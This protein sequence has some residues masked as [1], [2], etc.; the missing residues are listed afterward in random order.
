MRASWIVPV[1]IMV[2]GASALVVGLHAASTPAPQPGQPQVTLTISL[3][4]SGQYLYSPTSIHFPERTLVQITI[5]NYDTSTHLTLPLYDNVS[6]TVG[7]EVDASGGWVADGVEGSGSIH[8]VAPGYIS[9]TF[10]IIRNAYDVNVPIPAASGASSP[11]TVTF[12]LQ[13]LGPQEVMWICMAGGMGSLTVPGG[14]MSG[15]LWT[16]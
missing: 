10:S 11:A 2:V 1:A 4:A 9:H 5:V 13:I 12:L 8:M 7:N 15:S 14:G 6:G 3:D 16:Y